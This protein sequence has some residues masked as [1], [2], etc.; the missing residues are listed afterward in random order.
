MDRTL[1]LRSPGPANDT[2]VLRALVRAAIPTE[3]PARRFRIGVCNDHGEVYR[4][5]HLYSLAERQW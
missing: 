4:V 2:T 5:V 3:A 1:L